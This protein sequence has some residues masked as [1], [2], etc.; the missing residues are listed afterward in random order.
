MKAALNGLVEQQ[1]HVMFQRSADEVRNLLQKM[2]KNLQEIL[3]EKADEVFLAMRR[4]YRSVLGGGDLPQGEILPKAERLM[5]R[6][7]MD[8]I[9]KV[10]KIFRRVAGLEADEDEE[11][12]E[13]EGV[14]TDDLEPDTKDQK[15][16]V[17]PSP[18][19]SPFGPH[20][21]S[22]TGTHTAETQHQA[23]KDEPMADAPSAMSKVKA[24]ADDSATTDQT[25]NALPEVLA[26]V[27]PAVTEGSNTAAP[28]NPTASSSNT[29]SVISHK[30]QE[31]REANPNALVD[32]EFPEGPKREQYT[33]SED[34]DYDDGHASSSSEQEP[35][36]SKYRDAE[37]SDSD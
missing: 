11:D 12:S 29:P 24:E 13:K 2:V 6:A 8:K 3:D 33:D 22:T 15:R 19:L 30:K 20:Q 34:A 36:Q 23:V 14:P 7:I 17:S 21:L 4:D 18:H 37:R 35:W 10:E 16:H 9:D 1:R 28:A 27:N 26:V 5:R 32:H 25:S 31:D